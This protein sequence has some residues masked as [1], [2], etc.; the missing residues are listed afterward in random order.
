M[1]P[2][3]C[4]QHLKGRLR[5]GDVPVFL[6]FSVDMQEHAP[7]I[8]IWDL[9][10]CSLEQPQPTSVGRS[11]TS[12]IDRDAD[13]TQ[14]AAYLVAAQDNRQLFL[15]RRTEKLQRGPVLPESLLVEKLDSTQCNRGGGAGDLLLVGPRRESTG[16]DPA[17]RAG[18]GSC[19][20]V[21]RAGERQQRS[22][23][24]FLRRTPSIAYPPSSV[25]V[26]V[27]CSISFPGRGEKGP[28]LEGILLPNS[29][30]SE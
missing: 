10:M 25:D 4:A 9:K 19:D 12:V 26:T 11:Q 18:P 14:N 22:T 23:L 21:R 1:G 6:A 16:A 3:V 17:R 29:D 15:T 20:N 8:H 28:S 5:Q 24:E 2:P 13:F 30:G 27:S 7:T